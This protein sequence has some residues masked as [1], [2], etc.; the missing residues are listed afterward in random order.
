MNAT[1][2]S[3]PYATDDLFLYDKAKEGSCDG[4]IV[5]WLACGIL[6]IALRTLATGMILALWCRRNDGK[7]AKNYKNRWPVVP[8]FFVASVVSHTLL[9][10]LAGVNLVSKGYASIL[11]VVNWVLYNVPYIIYILKF[12][13]LGLKGDKRLRKLKIQHEDSR[14]AKMDA[15]ERFTLFLMTLCALGSI[16]SQGIAAPIF[17]DDPRPFFT[18]IALGG[19]YALLIAV[20]HVSHVRRLVQSFVLLHVIRIW[21]DLSLDIT[22]SKRP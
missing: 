11:M 20:L 12:V 9:W 5:V 13:R 14:L 16:I 6:A 10:V 8:V 21:T 17:F 2:C 3:F 7:N 19:I 1:G 18:G 15:G 4:N 22:E